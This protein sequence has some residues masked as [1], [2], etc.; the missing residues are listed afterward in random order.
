MRRACLKILRRET[1]SQC[2]DERIPDCRVGDPQF[3]TG[4]TPII[5]IGSTEIYRSPN[6]SLVGSFISNADDIQLESGHTPGNATSYRVFLYDFLDRS[7]VESWTF[8]NVCLDVS[9]N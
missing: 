5:G 6:V 9:K 4:E 1:I 2:S 7:E 8:R 3:E